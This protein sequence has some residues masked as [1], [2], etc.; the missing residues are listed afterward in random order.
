MGRPTCRGER[1][2]LYLD[3]RYRPAPVDLI[4]ALLTREKVLASAKGARTFFI[5]KR[6]KEVIEFG[7]YEGA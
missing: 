5:N 1:K 7:Y 6:S 2:T 4:L 3:G